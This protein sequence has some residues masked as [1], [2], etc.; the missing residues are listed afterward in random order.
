M[1]LNNLSPQKLEQINTYCGAMFH[2]DVLRGILSNPELSIDQAAAT[3]CTTPGHLQAAI[4][5]PVPDISTTIRAN[6]I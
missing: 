6:A 5:L 3:M 1:N 2:V 4:D